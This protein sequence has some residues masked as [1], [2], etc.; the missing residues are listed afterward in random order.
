NPAVPPDH[1][2]VALAEEAG[3]TISTEIGLLIERLPRR[4]RVIGVTGTAGKSTVTAM[5]GHV[6]E[7]V[8]D[9]RVWVGGNLGGSLLNDLDQMSD[10]DAV[11]LELS[12]F[13][14]RRL[15]PMEWSPGIAVMTNFSANHLDWHPDLEDYRRS[16]AQLFA[17]Q[18]PDAGDRAIVGPDVDQVIDLAGLNVTVIEERGDDPLARAGIELQLPGLHNRINARLALAASAAW[19]ETDEESLAPTLASFHGLPHRLHTVA[20]MDGVRYVDDSKSTTPTA[21]RLALASFPPGTI[22]L[23]VGG[24]D[25]GNDLRALATRAARTCAA[26]YT[27]GATGDAFADAAEQ[28]EDGAPVFRVGDVATGVAEAARRA[29]PGDVVLLSPACASWDQFDHYRHRGQVFARAV[30]DLDSSR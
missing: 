9:V 22:H 29:K 23:L 15:G 26:I 14:L 4:D 27:L 11:V 16:K 6:L 21:G 30:N 7:A 12:S 19:L 13:M 1:P 17:F 3:A 28:L 25:K 24:Y 20:E 2:M 18:Q 8:T 10:E 5:I